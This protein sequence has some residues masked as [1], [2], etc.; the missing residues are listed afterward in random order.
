M[1]KAN[2]KNVNTLIR[3]AWLKHPTNG[4]TEWSYKASC[5]AQLCKSH[6]HNF[7]LF[8]LQSCRWCIVKQMNTLT[9]ISYVQPQQPRRQWKA[10][11]DVNNRL[12]YNLR[13]NLLQRCS[14][15]IASHIIVGWQ[16]DQS[17][18]TS[19]IAIYSFKADILYRWLHW[20]V[21]LQTSSGTCALLTSLKSMI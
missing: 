17:L 1:R 13:R 3:I 20:L 12:R 10:D 4:V 2:K 14:W 16:W 5:T 8:Q 6:F 15:H 7:I 21:N 18:L 19:S 9:F 11:R